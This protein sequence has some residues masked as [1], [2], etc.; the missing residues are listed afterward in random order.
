MVELVIFIL[1]IAL[2]LYTVLGGA[3]FGAG[4]LEIF[5]GKSTEKRIS[6]AIA[7]VWEANHV[8]L[9][10][11]IVVVFNGFPKVYATLSTL[12]HIPLML[13][14]VGIIIRGTAF[15]FRHYD[16]QT[17]ESHK[18]Y[19][20]L[21]RVSSLLTPLV[22]GILL[23]A[24][25]LGKLP[26]TMEGSFYTIFIAPWLNSFCIT[27]GIFTGLLFTYI[28]ATFL[29]GEVKDTIEQQLYLKYAKRFHIAT[30]L[31]GV[32]VFVM[33]QINGLQLFSHFQASYPSLILVGVATI[34]SPIIFRSFHQ[35]KIMLMRLMVGVQVAA[36]FI[37]WAII[38]FPNF[39]RFSDGT[40]LT[41][42]NTAAPLA[43]FQQLVIALLIGVLIVIPAFGYLFFVFKL[44]AK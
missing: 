1:G 27:L 23:G 19:T 22:L 37:A 20:F 38:Q 11:V 32:L 39:L 5:T 34:S 36:I 9:I 17:D 33:A 43:T 35:N 3:D 16:V 14:L 7:P 21:F 42:Y 31:A 40:A 44:K 6:E 4:I 28:A 26:A 2:F 29:A 18:Y 13:L 30:V 24:M 15:T 8:W 12:L 41:I 25:I 10:L